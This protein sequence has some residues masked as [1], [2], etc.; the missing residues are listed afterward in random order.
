MRLL[1]SVN[2]CLFD[3]AHDGMNDSSRPWLYGNG[4]K[5]GLRAM[6]DDCIE[7]KQPVPRYVVRG[8]KH[9]FRVG[10]LRDSSGQI[11]MEGF[12]SPAWK[13]KDNYVYS[14]FPTALSS[15]GM[16]VWEIDGD[17]GSRWHALVMQVAQ[18]EVQEL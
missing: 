4:I 10:D 3:F 9:V 17:G 16:L 6:R 8:H 5:A 13:A 2:G 11:C 18:D 12:I 7:Y 1:A 14:R 15:I